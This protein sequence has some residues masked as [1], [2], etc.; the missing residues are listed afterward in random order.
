MSS[1][2]T[3]GALF[4]RT[5]AM[6]SLKLTFV[7]CGSC[8]S[9]L[10]LGSQFLTGSPSDTFDE[11]NAFVNMLK[12]SSDWNPTF[13]R[14]AQVETKDITA[15]EFGIYFAL[16]TI[17]HE[18]AENQH[19]P[20][21][22][23]TCIS[24]FSVPQPSLFHTYPNLRHLRLELDYNQLQC[25]CHLFDTIPIHLELISIRMDYRNRFGFF[26]MLDCKDLL[27]LRKLETILSPFGIVIEETLIH[28]PASRV[29]TVREIH[30]GTD[31]NKVAPMPL[32]VTESLEIV[33]ALN[34]P[35]LRLVRLQLPRPDEHTIGTTLRR[36]LPHVA[37][38]NISW[39]VCDCILWGP[40]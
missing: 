8:E 14:V 34:L 2:L 27:P 12:A 38:G 24:L 19:P 7:D 40:E 5:V 29:P 25:M 10:I 1:F 17:A 26:S 11:E 13:L 36:L 20:L 22:N 37:L 6:A 28:F 39:D 35:G 30:I 4:R 33:Q 9:F 21:P 18:D 23:I 15:E 3:G 32:M 31:F 16:A